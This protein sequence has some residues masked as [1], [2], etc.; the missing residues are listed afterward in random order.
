MNSGT[1]RP[2]AGTPSRPAESRAADRH[3]QRHEETDGIERGRRARRCRVPIPG[4]AE[5][6]AGDQRR[7]EHHADHPPHTAWWPRDARPPRTRPPERPWRRRRRETTPR[8]PSNRAD[9]RTGLGPSRRGAGRDRSDGPECHGR[10][11]ARHVAQNV[12]ADRSRDEAADHAL[13]GHEQGPWDAQRRPGEPEGRSRPASARAG[14]RPARRRGRGDRT[15]R[16]EAA[17]RPA[18]PL[19]NRRRRARINRRSRRWAPR[20]P[21]PA[22][23]QPWLRLLTR[24]NVGE[25]WISQNTPT[26]MAPKRPSATQIAPICM[27]AHQSRFTIRSIAASP[28]RKS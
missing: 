12:Q 2:P 26:T 21:A 24:P 3:H 27:V 10:P 11:V 4:R 9:V 20:Q 5:D 28:L 13:R 7:A 15:E 8:R 6:E 19:A 22:N 23:R 18:H 16:A 14:W 25:S 17:R 1:R